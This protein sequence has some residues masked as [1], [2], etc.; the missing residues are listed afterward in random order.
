[1]HPAVARY[2]EAE[3]LQLARYIIAQQL[4]KDQLLTNLHFLAEKHGVL[5]FIDLHEEWCKDGYV[6]PW[7]REQ[8]PGEPG[9]DTRQGGSR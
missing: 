8:G 9:A 7:E 1:M 3:L 6:L 4:T 5:G 2:R